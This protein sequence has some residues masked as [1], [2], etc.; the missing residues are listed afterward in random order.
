MVVTCQHLWFW[1][2]GS[3]MFIS[4][5]APLAMPSVTGS[6]SSLV[7]VTRMHLTPRLIVEETINAARNVG[8]KD[9]PLIKPHY[10]LITASNYCQVYTVKGKK[11]L[12]S[13]WMRVGVAARPAFL[14]G[15]AF[16]EAPGCPSSAALFLVPARVPTSRL[17]RS[18]AALSSPRGAGGG[19]A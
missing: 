17:A 1:S 11:C 14:L 2:S 6:R 9:V 10:R 18:V 13:T 8:L 19:G 15:M 7:L 3:L 4:P 12:L 5:S 16:S